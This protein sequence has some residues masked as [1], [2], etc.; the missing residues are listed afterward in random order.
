MDTVLSNPHREFASMLAGTV[1]RD[2]GRLR[3]DF[4]R[5]ER[6]GTTNESGD[7][8]SL[9]LVPFRAPLSKATAAAFFTG[10]RSLEQLFSAYR[11]ATRALPFEIDLAEARERLHPFADAFMQTLF[12]EAKRSLQDSDA[13][14]IA[15][16]VR[17]FDIY[18][19]VKVVESLLNSKADLA[20]L[21]SGRGTRLV[22]ALR[23]PRHPLR[24]VRNPRRRARRRDPPAR[25][26]LRSFTSRRGGLLSICRRLERL[27][28]V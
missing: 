13:E 27:S 12:E 26:R 14:R 28:P 10:V 22:R 7:A 23:S 17:D 18:V 4:D 24:L 3:L 25:A 21:R 1:L 11:E 5:P 2:Q 6:V 15:Q 19:A 20:L 9:N 16:W 8:V